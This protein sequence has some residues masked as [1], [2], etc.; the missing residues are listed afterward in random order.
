[1]SKYDVHIKKLGLLL[2]PTFFRK[3][4]IAGLMYASISV[5]NHIY[6]RFLSLSSEQHYRFT[7]N[8]Q[9]CYL[10]A[11]MNDTFDPQQRR[12][13][14]TEV[15]EEA[16]NS[17]IYERTVNSNPP[18]PLREENIAHIINRRGFSG[19][20]AYDFWVNIPRSLYKEIDQDHLRAIVN[21]YKLA[22]KR[23]GI[24]YK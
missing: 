2:L 22:S 19:A 24:N 14:I 10:R 23:F 13:T 9:V 1:M 11:V 18:A 7:H 21:T 4:L 20:Y 8:G 16:G 6:N 3:P 17:Y 5:L 12:I 15:A